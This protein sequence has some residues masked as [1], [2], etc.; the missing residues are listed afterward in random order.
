MIAYAK[1]IAFPQL[2]ADTQVRTFFETVPL[3][4]VT[5]TWHFLLAIAS[6]LC[7]FAFIVWM[8]RRDTHELPAGTATLLTCLRIFTVLALI[9]FFVNPQ[10]RSEKQLIKNSRVSILVD[11]SLSMGL[12]D[13]KETNSTAIRQRRIQEVINEFNQGELLTRLQKHHEVVVYQFGDET[14]PTLLTSLPRLGK[15]LTK[16]EAIQELSDQQQE[17]FQSSQS[18][19]LIGA[20]IAGA[21]LLIWISGRL[22]QFSTR[23]IGRSAWASFVSMLLLATSFVV[24]AI[25]N[26]M[27]P[28]T[29]LL[30]IAG[31]KPFQPNS[32]HL[33]VDE[34]VENQIASVDAKSI[35]WDD[36]LIP[37]GTSTKMGDALRYVVN[38]ERGGPSAGVVLFTDGR[39][40]AGVDVT[41]VMSSAN[42]AKIP[43]FCV[44]IGSTSS[45]KNIQVAD[46]RAPKRVFPGD[47]FEIKGLVQAFGLE[48]S[49]VEVT[50]VST[51]KESTEA[52]LVEENVEVVL[53][54]DGAPVPVQFDLTALEEGERIYRIKVETVQD[55]LEEKDNQ[56]STLVEIVKNK[57]RV[58]MIAGGPTR[59]YR[60][61]RNQLHRDPE[62]ILDVFL[63]TAVEGASQE[64]NEMVFEFPEDRKTLDQYDCIVAFDPDWRVLTAEQAE[65]LENWVADDAGGMLVVAGPVFTG[66]W[67]RRSQGDDVIDIL[68]RL[69][70]VSFF[71]AGS[72]TIRTGRFTHDTAFPI[73]FTRVGSAAEF[74]WIQDTGLLNKEAWEQFNGI[75]G[76]YAVNEA[77]A[78][79]D[80]FGHFSDP[81]SAYRGEKPIYMA[82]QLFGSGRVFFQGSGEMWRLRAVNVEYFEQYYRKLIR[83]VSQGRLN[84]DSS[85]GTLLL[86]KERCWLGDQVRIQAIL[87]DAQNQPLANSQVTVVI[88]K[89]DGKTQNLTLQ[90]SADE[91]RSGTYTAN[92]TALQQGDYRVNLP[93][94]DSPEGEVLVKEMRAM[95]TDLEMQQPQ[96][97]VA[98]LTTLSTQ[99]EGRF[100]EGINPPSAKNGDGTVSQLTQS[101]IPQDQ[102]TFL[103]G[104]TNR[105]FTR[106]LMIWIIAFL[107]TALCLEWTTRRLSKLA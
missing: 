71:N 105:D 54:K 92:F 56:K 102:E 90:R 89:P 58:F 100:F 42:D 72:G 44:G 81:E 32:D 68:R 27:T 30:T 93:I 45:P 78:G 33:L 14:N 13:T 76:Y 57:T 39:Q 97:N 9:L 61:L 79:A 10:Q 50:L 3:I 35:K 46:I 91:A 17:S 24:L 28:Q 34:L 7:A 16:S 94:P 40:N 22:Y 51:D 21:G 101:I 62:F 85:R 8:Y 6:C 95:I 98:L 75:F 49:Q 25:S 15:R 4:P 29:D 48:G 43:V 31:I 1:A 36:L 86:D 18:L 103:P 5:E 67:T 64:S 19:A 47:K 2:L 53:G 73:D 69:Y 26:L 11:T 104:T 12:H 99:T 88:R 74:L 84:R 66:E 37:R 41:T 52:E 59:E 83:W 55:E 87:K 70:P 63:Q 20:I 60:F 96:L 80:V 23:H 77:K 106:L 82:G 107:V 65:L 38:K